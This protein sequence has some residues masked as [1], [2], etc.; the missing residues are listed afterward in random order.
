[1]NK[2]LP[3]FLTGG[4]LELFCFGFLDAVELLVHLE[5]L[6]LGEGDVH[7][8]HHARK[9]ENGESAHHLHESAARLEVHLKAA[10]L[11]L[12]LIRLLAGVHLLLHLQQQLLHDVYLPS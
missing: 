8:A 1:M 9:T 3:R 7:H 12:V 4:V 10:G 5:Q 2:E 11:L 6:L